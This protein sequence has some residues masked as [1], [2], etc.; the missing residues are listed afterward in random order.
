[1]GFAIGIG[2]STVHG[3]RAGGKARLVVTMPASTTAGTGFVFT[4]TAKNSADQ[5]NSSYTG[6]VGFSSGDTQAIVPANATLASGVGTFSATLKTS[7][8]QVLSAVD[9][10]S[11]SVSGSVHATVAPTAAT[12]IFVNAP[13]GMTTGVASTFTATARDQFNNTA[14]G[15]TGLVRFYTTDTAG[16]LPIGNYPVSGGSG[17][18]SGQ[19]NTA[20]TQTISVTDIFTASITGSSGSIT[21]AAQV[22]TQIAFAGVPGSL[23]AGTQT[24]P[25]TITVQDA[26]GNTVRTY[27]GTVNFSSSDPQA[28]VPISA[29][30]VSGAGVFTAMLMTTGSQSLSAADAS[31]PSIAGSATLIVTGSN[32]FRT[33]TWDYATAG[34]PQGSLYFGLSTDAKAFTF[35]A[36]NYTK[37]FTSP[38]FRDHQAPLLFGKQYV[39]SDTSDTGTST[40]FFGIMGTDDYANAAPV[41]NGMIDFAWASLHQVIDPKLRLD[42][43]PA[44]WLVFLANTQS[45]PGF[46]NNLPYAAQ[47]LPPYDFQQWATPVALTTDGSFSWTAGASDIQLNHVPGGRFYLSLGGNTQNLAVYV[48]DSITGP[49]SLLQSSANMAGI[50]GSTMC[51]ILDMTGSKWLWYGDGFQYQIQSKGGGDW[52]SGHAP[53]GGFT[54]GAATPITYSGTQAFVS[55]S[56]SLLAA[57]APNLPPAR[58]YLRSAAVT[59]GIGFL[60]TISALDQY[61]HLASSYTGTVHFSSGD[62]RAVL[63]ADSTLARG[64]GIF[65]VTL[66]AAGSQTLTVNDVTNSSISTG[67]ALAVGFATFTFKLPV[68]ATAGTGFTFTVTAGDSNGGV[69]PSYTGTVHF[70][71]S[72]NSGYATLPANNTLA[73]GIGIFSA[74]LTGSGN[75]TLTATDAATTNTGTSSAVTVAAL[76]VSKFA[77]T[78]PGTSTAGNAITLSVYATDAYNNTIAGYTGTVTFSS[79]DSLATLPPNSTLTNGAGTFSLTYFKAANDKVTATDT[80]SSSITGTSNATTVAV[81]PTNHFAMS[82]WPTSTTGGSLI[83]GFVVS[84]DV[85]NNTT[86]SYSG[87]VHLTSSDGAAVLGPDNTLASGTRKFSATLNTA[88]N[89]TITATDKTTG[90][91][92]GATP[93]ITVS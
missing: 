11:S 24:G 6:T 63:P 84:R 51:P 64:V 23:A 69:D 10:A 56:V 74:T 71:S 28:S 32:V 92:T 45:S 62:T 58:F 16:V 40:T 57:L 85:G 33:S 18:F 31:T 13:S 79:A 77:L 20:G 34:D 48:S 38:V 72:D 35:T 81:G 17:V 5:T 36:A 19:L 44:P 60:A 12:H 42:N 78:A 89:Q 76:A 25:L 2:L 22:A 43:I 86:T 61:N 67:L 65:S 91:I 52:Q 73:A 39:L 26:G 59:S 55:P 87:T 37:P 75:R 30:L 66:Y 21:V 14:T 50:D 27:N 47:M 70:T 49:Y 93:S 1:V 15:Y 83:T 8:D 68:T 9:A 53:A 29:T 80:T 3:Q 82:L 54:F 7:G 41:G 90:S 46:N 4:V 88:G